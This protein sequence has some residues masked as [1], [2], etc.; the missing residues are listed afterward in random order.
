MEIL[1][2]IA[3]QLGIDQTILYVFPLIVVLYVLLSVFYLKPFQRHLHHRREKTEGAKKAASELSA[4]AEEKLAQYKARMKEIHEK[5][6]GI[7]NEN[8]EAAKKE[9]MRIVG[10]ASTK[11]KGTL[12]SAQKELE[13]QRRATLDALSGDIS[14]IATDIATKAMGRPMG[15]R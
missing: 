14:T 3:A 13:Q 12:Q 2:Q 7:V 6:R 9:E 1:A 8:R 4:R 15:A 10:E 11:A 5:S